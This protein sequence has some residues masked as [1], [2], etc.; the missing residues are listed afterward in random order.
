MATVSI[1]PRGSHPDKYEGNTIY[2]FNVNWV[3]GSTGFDASDITFSGVSFSRLQSNIIIVRT[4][5][6]N[7]RVTITIRENAVAEGNDEYVYGFNF[8]TAPPPTPVATTLIRVSGNNQSAEVGKPLANALVVQVNDQ[9]GDPLSGVSVSFTTTGGTLSSPTATTDSNGRTSVTI[10]MPSNAGSVTITARV[11]GLTDVTFTAT[12]TPA[13]PPPEPTPE[14]TGPVKARIVFEPQDVFYI[15]KCFVGEDVSRECI[16]YIVFDG[17]VDDLE[18]SDIS[19][20]A[21]HDETEE[22]YEPDEVAEIVRFEGEGVCYKVTIKLPNEKALASNTTL[23][24][25]GVLN[26]SIPANVVKRGNNAVSE[27][28]R[29]MT[30][31]RTDAARPS[32]LQI[33]LVRKDRRSHYP[34]SDIVDFGDLRSLRQNFGGVRTFDMSLSD[35]NLRILDK[36]NRRLVSYAL[37]GTLLNSDNISIDSDFTSFTGGGSQPSNGSN[38]RKVNDKIF[39]TDSGDSFSVNTLFFAIQSVDGHVFR[40]SRSRWSPTE[41]LPTRRALITKNGI[42]F[43]SGRSLAQQGITGSYKLPI[44]FINDFIDVDKIRRL[45]SQNQTPIKN[46]IDNDFLPLE[47]INLTFPD[48]MRSRFPATIG[49]ILAVVIP[50]LM[51]TDYISY[52]K[53][54]LTLLTMLVLS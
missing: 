9:N 2:F 33:G 34:L 36:P 1:T 5:A 3:G 14:P 41:L 46:T 26:V 45:L 54:R 4:N 48:Y 20:S 42:Y 7:G 31:R 38:A 25:S 50:M 30:N 53:Y 8:G 22:Q 6:G 24:D 13:P 52:Q 17:N 39:Y 18:Q 32:S 27:K 35:G 21:V 40:L 12:A 11:S 28:I 15:N 10:T 37:D 43:F 51:M 29:Y 16:A 47:T 19:V 44:S 49:A 23:F